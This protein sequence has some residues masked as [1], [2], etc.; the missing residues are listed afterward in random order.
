[1]SI[2]TYWSIAK[3]IAENESIAKSI[4]KY[5]S[6]TISIAILS[7]YCNKYCKIEKVLQYVLQNFKI[8]AISIAKLQKYCNKHCNTLKVV[9]YS[10]K[11]SKYY[12]KYCKISKVLQYFAILLEPPMTTGSIQNRVFEFLYV[13]FH[14]K[15]Y[16]YMEDFT[17]VN[18]RIFF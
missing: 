6:I 14:S 17:V 15:R 3:I 4:A 1:M 9:R 2:A 10:C 12:N 16:L 11:I 18:L 7:K 13:V 8:I 5:W